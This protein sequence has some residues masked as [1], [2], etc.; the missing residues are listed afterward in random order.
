[1]RFGELGPHPGPRLVFGGEGRGRLA[2]LSFPPQGKP[3]QNRLRRSGAGALLPSPGIAGSFRMRGGSSLPSCRRRSS[4]SCRS[5]RRRA[6]G[7]TWA[8]TW[9]A[10]ICRGPKPEGGHSREGAPDRVTVPCGG[11]LRAGCRQGAD[12]AGGGV[13]AEPEAEGC[14]R[15]TGGTAEPQPGPA[16]DLPGKWRA[17]TGG[18]PGRESCCWWAGRGE[19]P[20]GPWGTPCSMPATL[21][22]VGF[23]QV[24]PTRLLLHRRC[25]CSGR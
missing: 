5:P 14:L 6:C 22:A 1:M 11:V 25:P 7:S 18:R 10:G 19:G 21:V 23:G 17:P 9:G 8:R 16:E 2:D 20:C 15:G 4:R 12:A 24:S 13:S 3:R